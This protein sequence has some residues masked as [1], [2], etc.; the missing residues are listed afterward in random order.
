MSIILSIIYHHY[1]LILNL[2]NTIK[3]K[4]HN[5]WVSYLWYSVNF[6]TSLSLNTKSFI[7]NTILSSFFHSS[8]SLHSLSACLFV[9]KWTLLLNEPCCLPQTLLLLITPVNPSVYT[10]SKTLSI[11]STLGSSI[12]SANLSMN[13]MLSIISSLF[14]IFYLTLLL[15][16]LQTMVLYYLLHSLIVCA[17]ST[18]YL[19]TILL[20]LPLISLL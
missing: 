8:T 16:S 12:L 2:W 4:Y 14:L 13:G 15:T 6:F 19:W 10:L 7:L 5:Q 17:T 18:S 3:F 9:A 1:T 11:I 20:I